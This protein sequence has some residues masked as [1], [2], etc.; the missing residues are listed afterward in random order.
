M[1]DEDSMSEQ[2]PEADM[3]IE[4]DRTLAL[5]EIKSLTDQ[6]R[7]A[8]LHTFTVL[9]RRDRLLGWFLT[10]LFVASLGWV[11]VGNYLS[12]QDLRKSLYTACLA[13]NDTNRTSSLIYSDIAG[14]TSD[15]QIKARLILAAVSVK[16]IDCKTTYL[17]P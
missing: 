1:E 8:N 9:S 10:V 12:A 15:P 14:L 11:V 13:N 4:T 6:M 7:A 17:N 16:P 2:T 3:E 5:H